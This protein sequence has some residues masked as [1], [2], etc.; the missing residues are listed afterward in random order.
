M[1]EITNEQAIADWSN[2]PREVLD[3]FGDEGDFARQH[4]LNPAIFALLGDVRGK[5][6]LDAGCGQGYLARLLA[7]KG[8]LV[9]GIEPART[10]YQYADG[11]ERT[12]KLGIAYIQADLSSPNALASVFDYVVANM[13]LMD[14]P[15]HQAA[16]HHCIAALK[17]GGGLIFSI[18]HPCF[19]EPESEW[20]T[21]GC[22][23][24]REY[25]KEYAVPQKSF[26]YFFHR[27]LSS[28]VNLVIREQ[29]TIREIIEPQLD[30]AL[31]ETWP[32]AV[33]VPSFIVV[34]ATKN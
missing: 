17:P 30:E 19:D 10:L 18:L 24:V 9:T 4:L 8:A 23:E 7:R 3:N 21:K 27:T 32:R 5:R 34:H 15:D 6:V 29:C 1:S 14:I 28:Y 13:V 2:A 16:M 25:F 12:E 20:G 11:R 22:V 33:H 31:A 26:G